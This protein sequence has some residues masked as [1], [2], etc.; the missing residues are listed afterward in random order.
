[1]N[2]SF[3][4]FFIFTSFYFS[5]SAQKTYKAMMNDMSINFYDVCAE[6]EKYFEDKDINLKGSGWKGYMRWRVANE[7]KYYPDG[8]RS[9]VDQYFA[10]KAFQGFQNNS[11]KSLYSNGWSELGPHRVDSLTGH[12]SA[13]LGRIEDLYIDP[14]NDNRMYLGSRSGGFWKTTDGGTN[15]S[16]GVTDFLFASGVNAIGVSPTNPDSI[17]INVRNSRNG[18]T[19]GLYR[20]IDGGNTFS[21]SNF[22]PVNLNLGGLGS[23]FRIYKVAYHP[24]ISNLIFIGTSKGIYRSDDN[25]STWTNLFPS[26]DI[27]DITFHPTNPNIVYLYDNYFW[28][29]NEDYVLRSVDAGL[30]Y[31]KSNQIIGNNENRGRL[32]VSTS[33]PNCLYFASNNGIWKSTDNGMNFT[34]I[35][36]PDESCEGFVVN[37]LDQ[38]K[39]IYGYVDI[40][41]TVNEGFSFTDATRWSLG[42]TNAAGNGNQESF[43]NSTNYVHADLRIAKSV[44][45]VFY[46]GTDG[47]MAKST[48]NGANWTIVSQG[49]PIRENYKLGVSQSNHF[50]SISGSQDNGTSIKHKDDWIE[51]FGADGMEC[52]IHPL[53]DDWMIGSFQYG[54]RRLTKD[55]GQTQNGIS[56]NGQSGASNAAWEAPLAYDPNNQM[57]V[58]NF[59]ENVYVSEDFGE[60]W[61]ARGTPSS[62]S[63]IISQA[64]IAE[65]N[66][67]IIVISQNERIDKSTDGGATFFNIKSNLPN[68]SIQDIAFDP[69]NDDVIIVVYSRYQDDGRKV[70]RTENGGITWTNISYNLNDMPIHSV[71]IDHSNEA[72]IYLGGEIGVFT[73]PSSGT[74]WQLYNSN[75]PN[76]TIEELEIVY[77]SN[78]LKAATWGRGLW[79]YTLVDRINYPA[80]TTTKITDTPTE[81]APKIT[82]DQFVSATIS[83][84]NSLTAVYVEWSANTPSFGNVINMSKLADTTW[85]SDLALPQQAVGTKMYFKVFAVGSNNDTTETYKFMYTVTPF[86]YCQASGSTNYDG[87]ITLVNFNTIN[88]ATGKT[89]PYHDFTTTDSTV[90]QKGGNYDLSVNLNTDNGNFSY[91]SKVWI[92]WNRDASFD[93]NEE[94]DLGIT[95]NNSN[96]ATSFSALNITVPEWA[97]VGKTRMRVACKYNEYPVA[98]EQNMDGEVEDYTI[99]VTENPITYEINDRVCVNSK[100][101]FNYTG[102]NATSI[103]WTFTDGTNTYSATNFE[104]SITMNQIGLYDVSATVVINGE[105]FTKTEYNAF[106]VRGNINPSLTASSNLLS[107]TP[108][109]LNYTWLKCDENFEIINGATDNTYQAT[110]NGNYAVRVADDVCIDTTNCLLIKGISIEENSFSEAINI[111][112]NPTK[113]NLTIEM[114]SVQKTLSLSLFNNLGQKVWQRNETNIQAIEAVFPEINNGIYYLHIYSQSEKAIFKILKE[115]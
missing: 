106:I 96:G 111:F 31:T 26:G 70:Y 12:Y 8:D 23:N 90:V 41:R 108:Q 109:G 64:A 7:A 18:T 83:Y 101:H 43:R 11:L 48:D 85:V 113:G 112:P 34:F 37:D 82:K 59:S 93:S 98:C 91:Y 66:S 16:G 86:E 60:N 75:L 33:C 4:L 28:G 35:I 27:T 105:S 52:I 62:F 17:I 97:D 74:S 39:M 107:V 6:A 68:Y 95:S 32:S 21:E 55:G 51:F 114:G 79:E 19:H 38:T 2:K 20:S 99:I 47:M 100:I 84:Q 9:N 40:D 76:T 87:N 36:N 46:V 88:N 69:K 115:E 92:D 3:L 78:T 103:N 56:P 24:T 30:S 50:R 73:M 44:N 15:W 89:L 10:A 71:V 80:I 94:Y 29:Q 53:N 13:G 65:N 67:D 22:N 104:D 110:E 57:R 49:T 14:N 42:N 25:L 58:Y 63:G 72:N 81:S 102:A 5:L 1:M 45:G 54:G 77:G 61:T